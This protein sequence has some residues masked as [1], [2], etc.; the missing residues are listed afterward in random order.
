MKIQVAQRTTALLSASVASALSLAWW[1]DGRSAEPARAEE[2]RP[3]DL[4]N[5]TFL[6]ST[7]HVQADGSGR[8]RELRSV[9]LEPSAYAELVKSGAFPDG[10]KLAVT[11]YP[12]RE[13]PS[14][15]PPLFMAEKETF[16][17]LEVMDRSHP[18][19]RRFYVF[20]P[21]QAVAA[22]LPAGNA[23]AQCHAA[24]GSFEGTFAHAYPAMAPILARRA[25]P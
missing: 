1:T 21:G 18:D 12:L 17:G 11:F 22:A 2:A 5:W 13:D 19:G 3:Q 6:G 7:V 16:F 15:T 8:P 9:Q 14:D 10:A 20:R 25:K 23:C 4:H 24:R